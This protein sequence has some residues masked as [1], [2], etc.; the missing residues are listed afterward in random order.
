MQ[1]SGLK[2]NRADMQFVEI[3]QI[4]IGF[5]LVGNYTARVPNSCLPQLVNH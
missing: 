2:R 4:L 3:G 1:H 5:M